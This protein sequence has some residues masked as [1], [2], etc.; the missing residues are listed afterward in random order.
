MEEA[1]TVASLVRDFTGSFSSLL[2]GTFVDTAVLSAVC[3]V[4]RNA[5]PVCAAIATCVTFLSPDTTSDGEPSP[6]TSRSDST[7]LSLNS[8]DNEPHVEGGNMNGNGPRRDESSNSSPIT[9]KMVLSAAMGVA[10]AA[11]LEVLLKRLDEIN[12]GFREG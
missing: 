6:D 11:A 3:A 1:T 9:A 7:G 5:A 12:P 2:Q 10:L 4:C 8:N